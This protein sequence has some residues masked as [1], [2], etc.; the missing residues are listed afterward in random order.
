MADPR[1]LTLLAITKALYALCEA[2][3]SF[4]CSVGTILTKIFAQQLTLS[5]LRLAVSHPSSS[6]STFSPHAINDRIE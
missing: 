6:F 1:L 3:C 4:L 2:L 5:P